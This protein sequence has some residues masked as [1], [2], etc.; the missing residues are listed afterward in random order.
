MSRLPA[1]AVGLAVATAAVS[2]AQPA[3]QRND[4]VKKST[5]AET[6]AATLQAFGKPTLAGEW[7]YAGPFGSAGADGFDTAFPPEKGVDLAAKFTSKGGSAFGWQ[8][9]P[10]FKPGAVYDLNKLFP[11]VRSDAVVYLYHEFTATAAGPVGLSFGSDDS[12]TVFFNG[13][14]VLSENYKGP[15]APD[16]HQVEVTAQAGV[17]KLL[18]KVTQY[19][20]EWKVYIAP[21]AAGLP[22][23]V[24]TRINRDFPAA[25]ASASKAATPED[26]F[27]KVTTLSQPADC[28]LEV[29]G[30]GFR[31][32]GNLLACT[33]RGE[34]WLIHNPGAADPSDIKF[35]TFATGLHEAL[36]LYVVDNSTV[37]VVQRPE[38][39]KLF[40]TNGDGVADV[41]TT[42]SDKWGV[43]GDYH[44]F[45]FG[46]AVDPKTGDFFVT[47]NVGFG[48]GHQAK[49]AW[50]GWCVRIDPKTGDLEPWA[51][52]LRSPNGVNF[53]PDGELFYCDNQGEWV[54]TN[55]MHHVKKGKFYGH[56]AGLKW[57]KDSP[58]AGKVPD[59]VKS[60]MWYDGT[61]P[62]NPDAEKV[63]PDVDPPCIWFPY[64]R[65]GQSVTEPKWDTTGGKFGPFAGQCF[66]GDQ[67]RS[68]VMRV[69]LE[70]VN[71]VYQGAAFPFHGSLQSGVNRIA[72]G[73]DGAM[74]VGQ[75]ARGWGSVGGK[76]YGLQRLNYTGTLPFE[77]HNV[78]LTPT[79]FDLTFTKPVDPDSVAKP[80]AASVASFTYPYLSRYGAPETDTHAEPVTATRLSADGKTLSLVGPDLNKGRVYEIRLT[81]VTSVDGDPVVH[82]EAYY[83]LNELVPGTKP[84]VKPKADVKPTPDT[85]PEP[86]PKS[87]GK[88]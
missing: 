61:D 50:R 79:G 86:A 30:L 34:V 17:N 35:T 37:Y 60:G 80:A 6:V 45:A 14:R 47:L 81:G 68:T 56:Q 11:K 38:L 28:V 18:L 36:G 69:A 53:S 62:K 63:L 51:Y 2:L 70:K 9:V 31:P 52:G 48:G 1:L 54:A 32:D 21:E 8:P 25:V 13:K 78:K 87:D 10:N 57:V 7:H 72:F 20:G 58:F 85:E 76:P 40:D 59:V 55:K 19:A 71:G 27:Y 16:Q 24:R 26:T 46:P 73:P 4:Y 5:R 66:V 22:A 82:T 49:A 84:K 67:T 33:R 39:T 44:E 41:Y 83:T 64:G 3:G 29:G 23:A 15:V 77:I 65:M 88:K 75:T 42:V 74:Y 12:L 43:S